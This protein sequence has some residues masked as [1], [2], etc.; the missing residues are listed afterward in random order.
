MSAASLLPMPLLPASRATTTSAAVRPTNVLDWTC[1]GAQK[2]RQTSRLS[3][4]QSDAEA[5][6]VLQQLRS[7]AST[8]ELRAALAAAKPLT[9][10]L[11]L[12]IPKLSPPA[13]P[14]RERLVLALC[15]LNTAT[16]T[17]AER[18]D[19]LA[20][21]E[22]EAQVARTADAVLTRM[23]AALGGEAK[24]GAPGGDAA[25]RAVMAAVAARAGDFLSRLEA[26]ERRDDE[27]RATVTA[28]TEPGVRPSG[29]GRPRMAAAF[30]A[31]VAHVSPAHSR[32]PSRGASG[33]AEAGSPM[34]LRPALVAT[35]PNSP[36][37]A[38]GAA[39]P[40]RRLA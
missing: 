15:R 2:R 19:K 5:G 3:R 20:V 11:A 16:A 38:R 22:A 26:A 39:A 12:Q 14:A 35:D 13:D 17:A 31:L 28:A 29:T 34:A 24:G 40:K 33:K 8:D 32:P 36:R 23:E 9:T 18:L 30:E 7:A 25:D 21:P 4:E 10:S 37:P 27:A 6:A 1:A